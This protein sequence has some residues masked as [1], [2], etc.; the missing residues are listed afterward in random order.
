VLFGVKISRALWSGDTN[1]TLNPL[2][3]P[4][5]QSKVITANFTKRPLLEVPTW[6]EPMGEEGYRFL[7]TG[8]YGESFVV[9]ASTNLG[10]WAA[11]GMVA[12]QFGTLQFTNPGATNLDRRFYRALEIV[13]PTNL[14]QHFREARKES[15]A[16]WLGKNGKSGVAF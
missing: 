11:V 16:A 3:L 8:E 12:N 4:L 14:G 10:H 13:V 9:E 2:V 1:G 6:F 5:S 15:G 7:L